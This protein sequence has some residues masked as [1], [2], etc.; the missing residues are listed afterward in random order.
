VVHRFAVLRALLATL[1]VGC[2]P[3]T[4]VPADDVFSIDGARDSATTTDGALLTL[5]GRL[6]HQLGPVDAVSLGL[7]D[8][9]T[10]RWEINGCDF[11]GEGCGS[12]HAVGATIVLTP[13]PGSATFPWAAGAGFNNPT[14]HVDFVAGDAGLAANVFLHDGT[15]ASQAWPEGR[16]CPVCAGLGPSAVVACDTPLAA[17]CTYR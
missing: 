2:S 8:D 16:V 14:D 13:S 3:R 1:L 17:R 15:R 10:F 4:P 6:F 7:W 11:G 9:G 5:P 12:W